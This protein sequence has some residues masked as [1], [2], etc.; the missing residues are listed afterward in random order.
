M[1]I[2]NFIKFAWHTHSHI[3][4]LS[5]SYN[6]VKRVMLSLCF[7]HTHTH[8]V[9]L[10][11]REREREN[12]IKFC[13]VTVRYLAYWWQLMKK[14]D[15][16]TATKHTLS[17]TPPNLFLCLCECVSLIVIL[18][19][20]SSCHASGFFRMMSDGKWKY[21]SCMCVCL[22]LTILLSDY[23]LSSKPSQVIHMMKIMLKWGTPFLFFSLFGF[24]VQIHVC[25]YICVYVS[26]LPFDCWVRALL[27]PKQEGSQVW[28]S[29]FM[30]FSVEIHPSGIW[31]NTNTSH[32]KR[33]YMYLFSVCVTIYI[34]WTRAFC[35]HTMHMRRRWI[36]FAFC[37]DVEDT[38]RWRK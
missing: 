25:M 7:A 18:L 19:F 20:A 8:S 14:S 33:I 36:Q 28:E 13:E 5:N 3:L 38:D 1:T 29:F 37:V 17:K 26:C 23:K 10:V 12:E 11:E 22:V 24:H 34:R 16:F 2:E 32:L 21:A 6:Q 9:H 31:W 4:S 15:I 30:E 35:V 27:L